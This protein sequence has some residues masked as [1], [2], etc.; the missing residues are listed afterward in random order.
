MIKDAVQL[1][2]DKL[3]P[4]AGLNLPISHLSGLTFVKEFIVSETDKVKQSYAFPVDEKEA[5]NDPLYLVPSNKKRCIVWFSASKFKT[6]EINGDYKAAGKIEL[7]C[8]YNT[9]GYACGFVQSKLVKLL[10]SSV[11]GPYSD[12]EII[13]ALKIV[14]VNLE[15]NEPVSFGLYSYGKTNPESLLSPYSYFKITYD[16]TFMYS[17]SDECSTDLIVVDLPKC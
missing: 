4:L 8:W 13:K 11:A 7:F 3:K 5:Q 1:L 12:N 2:R 10:M 17:L 6:E 16:A 14:P 15:E 9:Q